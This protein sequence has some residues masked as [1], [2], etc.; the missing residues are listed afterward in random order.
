MNQQP[1]LVDDV[2]MYLNKSIAQ[3]TVVLSLRLHGATPDSRAHQGMQ[4]PIGNRKTK[5]S[6]GK[7]NTRVYSNKATKNKLQEPGKPGRTSPA[8]WSSGGVLV[9][10]LAVADPG[11]AGMAFLVSMSRCEVDQWTASFRD[12]KLPTSSRVA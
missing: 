6:K 10:F 1:L 3:H 4:K 5:G 9:A 8:F 12:A 11:V 7:S 2:T